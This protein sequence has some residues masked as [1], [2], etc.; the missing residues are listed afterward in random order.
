MAE[1]VGDAWCCAVEVT[2]RFKNIEGQRE[3]LRQLRIVQHNYVRA[4]RSLGHGF[5]VDEPHYLAFYAT[6]D[7]VRKGMGLPPVKPSRDLAILKGQFRQ[8]HHE[9]RRILPP[10]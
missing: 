7:A 8:T 4:K 2:K 9:Y 6:I 5:T 10:S 3:T 1:Q